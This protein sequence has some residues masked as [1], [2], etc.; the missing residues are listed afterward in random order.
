MH[1]RSSSKASSSEIRATWYREQSIHPTRNGGQPESLCD[2]LDITG[3]SVSTTV[4]TLGKAC[5]PALGRAEVQASA[6]KSLFR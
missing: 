5:Q 1:C 3:M 2:G 6:V 4:P